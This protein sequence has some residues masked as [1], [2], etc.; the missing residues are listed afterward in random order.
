MAD[1]RCLLWM[2]EFL[3]ILYNIPYFE[4]RTRIKYQV[5]DDIQNTVR[6]SDRSLP[7]VTDGIHRSI[8][9]GR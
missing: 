9:R 6:I 4:G 1:Y 2:G 7:K 5:P 8:D 3:N